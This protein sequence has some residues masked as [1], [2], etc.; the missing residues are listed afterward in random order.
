[1]SFIP[2]Y[3]RGKCSADSFIAGVMLEVRL[4]GRSRK[5]RVKQE[6]PVPVVNETWGVWTL[7]SSLRSLTWVFTKCTC[8]PTISSASLTVRLGPPGWIM[9]KCDVGGNDLTLCRWD[10]LVSWVI[11]QHS[12][13][14]L[15]WHWILYSRWHSYQMEAVWSPGSLTG[16]DPCGWVTLK[17]LAFAKARNKPW[18]W[19]DIETWNC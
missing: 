7:I 11:T 9:T 19:E 2:Y 1:M 10:P 14:P 3:L 18:L 4:K 13:S 16:G 12:L 5:Q 8:D 6:G 17:T 15:G